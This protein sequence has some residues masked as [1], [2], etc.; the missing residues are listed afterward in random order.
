[1]FIDKLGVT[2][3]DHYYTHK[4]IYGTRDNQ[5]QL[6]FY[7]DPAGNRAVRDGERP[8]IRHNINYT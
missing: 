8:K 4:H 3:I 1:M 6:V 5:E 7:I 2:T